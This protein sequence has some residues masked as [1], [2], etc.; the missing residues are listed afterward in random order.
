MKRAAPLDLT[1]EEEE[2]RKKP[3]STRFQSIEALARAVGL[4]VFMLGVL[5]DQ[6]EPKSGKFTAPPVLTGAIFPNNQIRSFCESELKRLRD[7]ANMKSDKRL[8]NDDVIKQVLLARERAL[9]KQKVALCGAESQLEQLPAREIDRLLAWEFC[10][11]AQTAWGYSIFVYYVGPTSPSIDGSRAEHWRPV[12]R[13]QLACF[14]RRIRKLEHYVTHTQNEQRHGGGGGGGSESLPA[15]YDPRFIVNK[16]KKQPAAAERHIE[17]II[18]NIDLLRRD[19]FLVSLVK[20]SSSEHNEVPVLSFDVEADRRAQKAR[21]YVVTGNKQL[22][23]VTMRDYPELARSPLCLDVGFSFDDLVYLA[24]RLDGGR[25]QAWDPAVLMRAI[26]IGMNHESHIRR[27]T[28]RVCDRHKLILERDN[29]VPIVEYLLTN[30]EARRELQDAATEYVLSLLACDLA[31]RDPPN[32]IY[33]KLLVP[34][35]NHFVLL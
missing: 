22:C 33:S 17:T 11:V 31:S 6:Y 9:K 13:T 7:A 24:H 15:N 1:G 23:T 28:T 3:R 8:S 14:H 26:I 5:A 16:W 10:G 21:G 27:A 12:H 32:A 34:S 4:S 29:V 30:E 35:D 18:A 2:E 25:D 20:R 19:D